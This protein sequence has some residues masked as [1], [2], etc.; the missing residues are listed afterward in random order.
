MK[1]LKKFAETKHHKRSFA[2]QRRIRFRLCSRP[3]SHKSS[4]VQAIGRESMPEPNDGPLAG[5]L[6][7]H[8]SEAPEEVTFEDEQFVLNARQCVQL[9]GCGGPM[10]IILNGMVLT[11]ATVVVVSMAI[12]SQSHREPS[13]GGFAWIGL[14][15]EP[16]ASIEWELYG[17]EQYSQRG[18]RFFG[19]I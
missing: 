13:S 18:V 12:T 17:Y 8:G 14:P 9:H 5:R 11:G 10:L 3:F 15:P 4:P 16:E 1:T 7:I 6:D 19:R 2:H